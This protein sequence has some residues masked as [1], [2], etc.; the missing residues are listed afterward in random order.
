MGNYFEGNYHGQAFILFGSA[1]L[2]ALACILVLNLILSR[3]RNS[4]E[5]TKNKIRWAFAIILWTNELAWHIWNLAT[6]QWSIQ[7]MLPLNVCSILIWLSG[8]MLITRNYRL[9]EFSYFLGI[10]AGIQ[11]LLTPDLGIYGFP[12]FRFIQTYIAHGLLVTAPI[13]MTVVERFRPTFKSL[14]RVV[15][16]INVYMF[17]IFILNSSIGSDYLMINGKPSTPSILDLLPS[18]PYYIIFMELLGIAT[19]LL[20]YG[21]IVFTNRKPGPGLSTS[22]IKE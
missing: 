12:H 6:G 2:T 20:L 19:F 17:F 16:G 3:F 10:G 4:D 13:Y 5:K 22:S 15:F 18:W 21:L 9:Y 1:H 7:Y 11:Y 14:L 8:Y